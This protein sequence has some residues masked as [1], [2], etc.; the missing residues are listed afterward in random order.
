MQIKFTTIVFLIVS[1]ISS[2][3][4]AE[5]DPDLI[6]REWLLGSNKERVVFDDILYK[7]IPEFK[8]GNLKNNDGLSKI[9]FKGKYAII[10]IW[11]TWCGP[12]IASI[13]KNN[14]IY[15]KYNKKIDFIGIC[16]SNGS[17]NFEEIVKNK[18]IKYPVGVDSN[19]DF[20]DY[21]KPLGFPTYH[22]IDPDGRLIVADISQAYLE[23]VL[24]KILEKT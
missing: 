4:T 14:E 16:V 7:K 9:S 18:G 13:P 12:C 5:F 10:D 11:A 6:R 17:E 21:F 22:L 15:H 19:S 23:I 3:C 20:I 24:K 2:V 8:L 1:T